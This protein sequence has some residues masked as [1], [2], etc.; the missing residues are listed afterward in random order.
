MTC[1]RDDWFFP[2]KSFRKKAL[3]QGQEKQQRIFCEKKQ[4]IDSKLAHCILIVQNQII[5]SLWEM[6]K[7]ISKMN[8][9]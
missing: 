8:D 3:N 4:Q 6:N 5:E 1:E 9:D 7:A 2:A